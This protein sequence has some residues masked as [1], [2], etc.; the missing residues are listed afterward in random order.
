MEAIRQAVEY[1]PMSNFIAC[2]L[3]FVALFLGHFGRFDLSDRCL[4]L[5]TS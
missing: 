1:N 3:L 4:L 2:L 5:R